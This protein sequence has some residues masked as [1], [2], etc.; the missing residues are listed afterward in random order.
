MIFM[1]NPEHGAM[2][3]YSVAESLALQK[4]G[5]VE[6]TTEQWLSSKGEKPAE[7]IEP[8]EAI[9]TPAPKKRGRPAK[10]E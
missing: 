3:S 1:T 9:D 5:W 4:N 10:A 7:A 2:F 6:S 8:I